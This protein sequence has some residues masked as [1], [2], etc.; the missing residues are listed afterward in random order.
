[1][2]ELKIKA[3]TK[4]TG[5]AAKQVTI[6]IDSS[7]L[8]LEGAWEWDLRSDAVFCS[9]VMFGLPLQFNGTTG[10]IHPDDVAFLKQTLFEPSA[11]IPSLQ[12][13]IITTY[14]EVRTL[15]GYDLAIEK[16]EDDT[17]DVQSA[18]LQQAA[19]QLQDKIEKDHLLL[20][21][22]VYEKAEKFAGTGV[23]YYNTVSTETWYSSHIFSIYDLPP[24][25]LNPHVNTFTAFIHP[26]DLEL[27]KEY[28]ERAFKKRAP[29]H[30]EYRIKTPVAV[31]TVLLMT[32]WFFSASG[33][34]I[35]SGTLQ[36]V[37]EQ[38]KIDQRIDDADKSIEFLRKQS[39]YDEEYGRM[40]H[41]QVSLLTRKMTFSDNLYRIYGLKPRSVAASFNSIMDFIHM[42]DRK[43]VTDANKKMFYEHAV[44]ELDYRILR[45]DGKLRYLSQKARIISLDGEMIV[46]GT[47]QDVTTLKLLEKKIEDLSTL[48]SLRESAFGQTEQIAGAATWTWELESGRS[49]WSDNFYRL[50]G[51]K[52]NTIELSQKQLL[53]FVHPD[54]QKR[55]NGEL[56]RVL[57]QKEESTFRFRMVQRGLMRFMEA[58]FRVLKNDNTE[59]FIGTFRDLSAEHL[60]DE[61]LQ[62]QKQYT[63]VL[64]EN[65]LDSI[66]ITD[67][68]NTITE[69]N[70]E[71]ESAFGVKKEDALGQ[72]FF[73]LFPQL[74]TEDIIQQFRK[75]MRGEEVVILGHQ[76]RLRKGYHNIH[77]I[78]MFTENEPDVSS[79]L[80][81]IRDVT[82]EV[83]LHNTLNER[84]HFISS[85]LEASVDRIIALDRNMNYI[86]WNRVAEEYYG[87][88]KEHVLGKNILEI[89][90]AFINDPSYSDFRR[91]LKGE[92]V[93]STIAADPDGNAEILETYLIP[94]K[95]DTGEVTGVLWMVRNTLQSSSL[96]DYF[97]DDD[98][99]PNA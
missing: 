33:E 51:Y 41:W 47:V 74:K 98:E 34:L 69:W 4:T 57:L 17:Q 72:N 89:F 64:A 50:L 5:L 26:E 25:S 37:S 32:N 66:F 7:F 78:P 8:V 97:T 58:H 70:R 87:L 13:R 90:P 21:K 83:E 30:L 77:M 65:A 11:E 1:L 84:L 75:V 88:K 19:S 27:V 10:I 15:T 60:L 76:S 54:D 16:K 62:K 45:P 79:V 46:C 67:I 35:M 80:H 43:A 9:D 39:A 3:A 42:D 28:T 81:I 91:A 49:S 31:K 93:Q 95:N 44:P 38:K 22:D 94:V 82:R 73:D 85:L 29:I 23:F 56:T 71:S 55:F 61:H 12:F 24:N 6:F 68:N 99:Q 36:D 92:L 96:T 86:Y 40:G 59:L 63:S 48:A 2:Q 53:L 18:M 52:P 14:G 20:L